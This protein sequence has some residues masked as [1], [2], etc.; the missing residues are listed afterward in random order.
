MPHPLHKSFSKIK[1]VLAEMDL[2]LLGLVRLYTYINTYEE[3]CQPIYYF[4]TLPLQP[5]S[6]S[7]YS[8]FNVYT[9]YIE[10]KKRVVRI[11]VSVYPQTTY[12]FS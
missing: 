11:G 7:L 3:N 8:I 4:I 5:F 9:Y 6:E 1:S 2:I 10:N 12:E